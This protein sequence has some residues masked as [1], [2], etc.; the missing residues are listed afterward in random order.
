M[1]TTTEA[2]QSLDE[3]IERANEKAGDAAAPVTLNFHTH[4]SGNFG[5]KV[6]AFPA[7]NFDEVEQ[8]KDL[9]PGTYRVFARCPGKQGT[10]ASMVYEHAPLGVVAPTSSAPAAPP[11]PPPPMPGMAGTPTDSIFAL[12]FQQMQSQQS[13]AER[14]AEAAAQNQA[15]MM[16]TMM[17]M[18]MKQSAPPPPPQTSIDE[19]DRLMKL[20]EQRSG[21]DDDGGGLGDLAKAIPGL[22]DLLAQQKAQTPPAAPPP[23]AL[24]APVPATPQPARP[25]EPAPASPAQRIAAV[26]AE[27]AP[28]HRDAAGVVAEMALR[29]T[30]TLTGMQLAKA[31]PDRVADFIHEFIELNGVPE[32]S[33]LLGLVSADVW[34]AVLVAAEPRLTAE[35]LS[36]VLK[37]ALQTDDQALEDDCQSGNADQAGEGSADAGTSE[38]A[39]DDPEKKG[40]AR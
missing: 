2:C 25:A 17:Q 16:Q 30:P 11:P 24:P 39:A 34:S 9:P 20:I 32:P 31:D 1:T 35:F 28:E 3:L 19:L 36:P 38:P 15:T 6:A 14:R 5:S 40:K 7:M 13:A 8:L 21:G 33:A 37:L 23:A 4:G 27:K 12:M 22:V 26:L 29:L 10:L 18:A